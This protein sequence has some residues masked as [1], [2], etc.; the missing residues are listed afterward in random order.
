MTGNLADDQMPVP[1][2]VDAVNILGL[3]VICIAFG[4]TLGSMENEAKP[5]MDLLCC[6]NKVITRLITVVIW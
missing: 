5:M 2:T 6:L 1:S 4:L 3:I